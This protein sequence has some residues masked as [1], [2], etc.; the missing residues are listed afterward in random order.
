MVFCK[1][2]FHWGEN[3]PQYNLYILEPVAHIW[4][5]YLPSTQLIMSMFPLSRCWIVVHLSFI[6][7]VP[8]CFHNVYMSKFFS[9]YWK[10]IYH[11]EFLSKFRKDGFVL[12][13]VIHNLKTENF[14]KFW[15]TLRNHCCLCKTKILRNTILLTF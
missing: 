13:Y 12:F 5:I 3:K 1:I 10:S 7:Y 14:I 2:V 11:S 15:F 6:D 9:L 4:M 8:A